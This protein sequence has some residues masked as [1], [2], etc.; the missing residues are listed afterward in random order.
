[1]IKAIL[2]DIDNTLIDFMK[3]KKKSC[4][5]AVEAMIS[6]G[7]KMKEEDAIKDIYE[8]YNKRGM[9][10]RDVFEK[11]IKKS[12]GKLDYKIL[13]SGVLAYR[14]VKEN[15]LV[16]Y[17]GVIPVLTSLKKKYK[18]GIVSDAP[19]MKAWMRLIAMKIDGL[20]DVV[21]TKS[22]VKKQKNS[23]TPFNSALK[24]LNMKPEEVLMVGDRI[25]R[26][27]LTPK[28]LGIKTCFA[29]YGVENP[30]VH[31]KS[32]ADFEINDFAELIKII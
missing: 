13:A 26:D 21:I 4:E 24:Q 23:P 1:M 19:S 10:Y 15:Y 6:A 11:I 31:E 9:E 28:K 32:G 18:L 29:R 5:A 17:S 8:I 14:K 3:M 22:D 27:I 2:L 16:P 30:P 20:F 25:E 12:N 7:L